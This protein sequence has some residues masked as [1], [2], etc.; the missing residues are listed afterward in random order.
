M[1]ITKTMGSCPYCKEPIIATATRCKHCHADLTVISKSKK[2]FFSRYDRFKHGFVA[3]I[4][5]A[6]A[7]GILVYFQFF[8][9]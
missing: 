2:S 9:P 6:L 5:F 7:M 3:G 8:R 1:T 4:I